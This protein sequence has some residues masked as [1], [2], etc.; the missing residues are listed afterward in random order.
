MI[1]NKHMV[2]AAV[3]AATGM[4]CFIGRLAR[5]AAQDPPDTS[6]YDSG[7]CGGYA[8]LQAI[9]DP[10]AAE[11]YVLGDL[12]GSGR[13]DVSDLLIFAQTQGKSLGDPGFNPEADLNCDTTVDGADLLILAQNWGL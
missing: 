1:P 7:V 3:L 11:Q 4:L 5:V 12:N 9:G 10:A 2:L 8:S 13:V 6:Y